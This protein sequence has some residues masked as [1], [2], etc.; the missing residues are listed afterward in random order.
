MLWNKVDICTSGEHF[1]F[2]ECEP[3]I[4]IQGFCFALGQWFQL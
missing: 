3:T 2:L 1:L 4:L